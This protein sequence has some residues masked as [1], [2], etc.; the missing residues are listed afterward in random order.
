MVWSDTCRIEHQKT[1][2]PKP[3]NCV[4]VFAHQQYSCSA[5]T[6][7]LPLHG[8][9]AGHAGKRRPLCV[10]SYS[11]SVLRR[12]ANARHAMP[13]KTPNVRGFAGS[14]HGQG[15]ERA[16]RGPNP[17]MLL[18]ATACLARNPRLLVL[19]REARHNFNKDPTCAR[20]ATRVTLWPRPP[21]ARLR[22]I[23]TRG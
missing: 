8:T 18:E 7:A 6:L 10:C 9:R 11:S 14:E 21:L 15:C 17:K 2:K 16:R 23:A 20:S 12:D 5:L 22:A 3:A 13:Q 1:R 4:S 19:R